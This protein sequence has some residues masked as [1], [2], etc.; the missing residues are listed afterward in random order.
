[1]DYSLSDTDLRENI[2]ANIVSYSDIKNY[3]TIDEL[4]GNTGKCFILYETKKNTGHWTCL[5][6]S[7]L[8]KTNKG[9]YGVNT[10]KDT[11]Y[12]FDPYGNNFD[13]QLNFIPKQIN[14]SLGQDHKHLIE[15]LYNSPYK[16]EFNEYKLQKL[17]RGINT[18]GRWCLVR[19]QNPSI[20]VSNFKNLFSKKRLGNIKPDEMIVR[21][22]PAFD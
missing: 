11:I 8:E 14:K 6:K 7:S 12:F 9:G 17:G 10:P 5:Y 3:K 1:M 18:C 13:L 22:T 16:V 15:L 20:S 4:L 2:D 19:L 21:L